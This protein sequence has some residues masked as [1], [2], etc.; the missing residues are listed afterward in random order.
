MKLER[1]L[2]F[3]KSLIDSHINDESIVIDATCGNGNDTYYLASKVERGFVYGFDIQQEAIDNTR[4]KIDGFENVKLILDG[5]ENIKKHISKEH[6][7]KIDA[8]IFNLGYLPK[9][10]KAIV[11]QPK[12]TIKAIESIFEVLS[13]EG[14]IILVIYHGHEEGK[15]ERDA[16]IHYLSQFDQN[17]AHI[18]Q[19]QFINQKNHAPFLCAIEKRN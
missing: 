13:V 6:V 14:I 5:H 10:N 16:L 18:L 3:S 17:Q 19:Y 4:L 1:I 11:T 9:G 2:P 7:G 8:A 12:T 15:I